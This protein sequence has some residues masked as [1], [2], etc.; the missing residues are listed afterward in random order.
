M[1]NR[2]PNNI[3]LLKQRFPLK[4]IE[5]EFGKIMKL[6]YEVTTSEDGCQIYDGN[7][8]IIDADFYNDFH[9]NAA[10]AIYAFYFEN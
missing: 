10:S 3:E 2:V 6:G 8:L 1:K 9:S 4:D 5:K 7:K